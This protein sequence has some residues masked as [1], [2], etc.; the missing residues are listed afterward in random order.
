ME[1]RFFKKLL[2]SHN[3][4]HTGTYG[5]TM[6][7]VVFIETDSL[8]TYI[9]ITSAGQE[10]HEGE[11]YDIKAKCNDR[12]ILTYVKLER[13][14]SKTIPEDHMESEQPDHTPVDVFDL[15][16]GLDDKVCYALDK[17]LNLL[18]N[19]SEKGG[20]QYDKHKR[21]AK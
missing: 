2:C 17:R 20:I 10:F 13:D 18:Y 15:I 11:Y 21:Y 14:Y 5:K 19:S 6:R 16:Y 8:M 9:W 3:V 7:S 12:R 4:T 1:S